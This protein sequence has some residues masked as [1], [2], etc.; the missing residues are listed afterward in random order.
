MNEADTR[1]QY[2]DPQLVHAGW[3]T[4]EGSK[5]FREFRITDGR[6]QVGGTRA[7]PDIADYVLEYNGEKLAVIEAKRAE[8]GYT[9]GVAQAKL[10]AEKLQAPY[11][12][13]SNGTEL[14]EIV[15]RTGEEKIV[16]IIPTPEELWNRLYSHHDEWRQTFRTTPF[17]DIGGTK[18]PRYYQENAVHKVLDNIAEENNRL[19]LTLATGTGKTY[20]AFQIAWKLFHTRWNTKRDGN[21]RPRILFLADRNILADQ[22]FNSFSAF[23]EDALV[24]INP[25]DIR[26]RGHVP[27]NGSIFFTIFQTFMSG[28]N[29]TAYYGEY[30]PDFFDCII[31][32]ECHRGGANDES[33]WRAILEHF[34]PA[35]QIGLTATPKR[36]DNVDTYKYFGEPVYTY[37]LKS[38]INDGFLTPFKVKRIQTT[39][40]EYVYTSDDEI[41]EGEIEAGKVYVEEDFNRIIQIKEREEKRVRIFLDE[42][43]QKEKTIVFCAT[44]AHAA[45]VRDL[46]NQHAESKNPLYCARVTANDGALGEQH[47]RDFQDNE[48]TIPTILTTSQKLSTGV[49]ARNVRNIVLMRP[50]N[51]MIEFKQIVGRGT[52]LFEGKEYFTIYD[53][54]GAYKHFSDPE[55]DGEPI[56]QTDENPED[57]HKK[58]ASIAT[59]KTI[60]TFVTYERPEKIKIKLRDGKEREISHMISTSFWSADGT[61]MSAQEFLEKMFGDLPDFFKSEEELRTIWSNPKTRKV[62]L[63]NIANLGYGKEQLEDLQKMIDAEDSDLFDVLAYVSFAS[64]PISRKERVDETKG[65]IFKELDSNAQEFITFVLEK[66]IEEGVEEL[67]EQKLPDLLRLKYHAMADAEQKLG[68]VKEIRSIFFGF[69]KLLYT[70]VVRESDK[71]VA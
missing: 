41:V 69:Q 56:D 31:I 43:N 44:Q 7:K 33:T 15:M 36:I 67:D 2:I 18:K 58:G 46:I 62:F 53:F 35:V 57:T 60:T 11:A 12:Y 52:R 16:D 1:A 21:R 37:S 20:I 40:D 49:D 6:I 32:D 24:R 10:Y 48:K 65:K 63:D 45:A 38:G 4:T 22:A 61:P 26:R 42:I 25:A 71:I 47:L 29:D 5:V 14:Y 59:S 51:S 54:V 28:P 17:E 70:K 68:D 3:G 66:Y 34:S 50:V 13:A 64:T 9:E 19:L 27:T 8:L 55:W 30:E 39:L 23:P